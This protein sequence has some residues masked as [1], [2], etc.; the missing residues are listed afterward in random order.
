V[1]DNYGPGEGP[2]PDD[3]R[4]L[5]EVEDKVGFAG[6]PHT[7]AGQ[8]ILRLYYREERAK[9]EAETGE[10]RRYIDQP[11]LM[12][13]SNRRHVTRGYVDSIR[14]GEKEVRSGMSTEEMVERAVRRHGSR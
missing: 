6:G 13:G 7:K 11:G 14:E 4:R 8:E 9:R 10:G 3:T 1:P 12:N 2:E 5:R